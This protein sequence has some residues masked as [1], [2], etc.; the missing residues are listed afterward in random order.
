MPK[1]EN[2]SA[3]AIHTGKTEE[4]K[5]DYLFRS[6]KT[7]GQT[8]K[9][10]TGD[11]PRKG[12]WFK[13]TITQHSL[14]DGQVVSLTDSQAEHIRTRGIEKEITQEDAHGFRAPTGQSYLDT[15]F[16]LHPC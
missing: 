16:E 10:H 8:I 2:F 5:R 4:P 6:R 3:P 15:R 7:P 12:E 14:T 13:D 11:C 9:C 1:S